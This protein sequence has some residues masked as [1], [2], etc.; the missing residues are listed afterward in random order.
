MQPVAATPDNYWSDS[1]SEC[2]NWYKS[3]LRRRLYQ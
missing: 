3:G 1:L 2:L